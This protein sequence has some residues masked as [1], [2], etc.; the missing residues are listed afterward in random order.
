[1]KSQMKDHWDKREHWNYKWN[2][3]YCNL[4]SRLPFFIIYTCPL[5]FLPQGLSFNLLLFDLMFMNYI[6]CKGKGVHSYIQVNN[7]MY[8]ILANRV[9]NFQWCLR[10]YCIKRRYHIRIFTRFFNCIMNINRPLTLARLAGFSKIMFYFQ[11]YCL[12]F[13]SW[14]LY[15]TMVQWSY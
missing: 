7:A 11:K 8:H 1:M 2:C 6:P 14:A 3:Y 13:S 12:G 15:P 10:Y 9:L 4:I 5:Y